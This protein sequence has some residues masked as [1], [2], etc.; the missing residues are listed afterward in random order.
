[1]QSS[2]SQTGATRDLADL[3]VDFHRPLLPERSGGHG[4]IV[5][6]HAA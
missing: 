3:Q 2:D 4:R 6:P 1:M 5:E